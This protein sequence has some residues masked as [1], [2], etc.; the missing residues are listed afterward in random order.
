[1]TGKDSAH[2]VPSAAVAC[3]QALPGNDGIFGDALVIDEGDLDTDTETPEAGKTQEPEAEKTKEAEAE[4]TKEALAEGTQE[5]TAEKTQEAVAEGTQKA[6]AQGTLDPKAEETKEAWGE[7][8]KI[9]EVVETQDS[10]E[11]ET[12]RPEVEEKEKLYN[13]KIQQTLPGKL[14]IL[15]RNVSKPPMPSPYMYTQECPTHTM[16]TSSWAQIPAWASECTGQCLSV[17]LASHA[18]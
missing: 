6:E 8:T 1:M 18:L 16:G 7:E 12:Q 4:K 17:M 15:K 2:S 3:S 14:L 10:E 11:K 9:P 5:A 13:E